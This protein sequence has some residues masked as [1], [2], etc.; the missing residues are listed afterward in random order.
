MTYEV[1]EKDLRPIIDIRNT[2]RQKANRRNLEYK[3]KNP[4][5][6]N[7]KL[8]ATKNLDVSNTGWVWVAKG[9]EGRPDSGFSAPPP[10]RS[11]QHKSNAPSSA[12]AY[13]QDRQRAGESRFTLD[14]DLGGDFDFKDGGKSP[15]AGYELLETSD[16][17]AP[18]GWVWIGP[19]GVFQAP[20]QEKGK[21][22][23]VSQAQDARSRT[24][25]QRNQG[26]ELSEP[27]RARQAQQ[28]RRQQ[29][30]RART[31]AAPDTSRRSGTI[32][33]E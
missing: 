1:Y 14:M 9:K 31:L 20:Y 17:R 33:G 7:Y 22:G 6:S 8:M 12:S 4:D 27:V 18:T 16:P 13:R 32:L 30:A 2:N 5:P 29:T 23:N 19:N 28:V 21:N 10:T 26:S 25:S 3:S 24:G 15:G 11:G